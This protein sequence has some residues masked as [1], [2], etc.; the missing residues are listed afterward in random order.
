MSGVF[1]PNPCKNNVVT[2]QPY[3][4]QLKVSQRP[5]S[6]IFGEI[7]G[8]MVVNFPSPLWGEGRVRGL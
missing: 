1:L 8:E 4:S 5:K 3:P 6:H 2:T 7:G